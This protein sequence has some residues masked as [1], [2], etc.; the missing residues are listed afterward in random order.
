MRFTFPHSHAFPRGQ[1]G[2]EEDGAA[3]PGA[4]V[5]FGDGITLIGDWRTEGDDI[6]LSVPR[7]QTAKGTTVEARRWRLTRNAQ[8]V[9]RCTRLR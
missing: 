1:V 8:G 6:V 9:W 4:L 5:E 7:Y 3:P 2:V